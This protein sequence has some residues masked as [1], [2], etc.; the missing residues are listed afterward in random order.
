[1]KLTSRMC[2]THLLDADA[3]A[4]E[5]RAEIDRLAIE[6]DAPAWGHGH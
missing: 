2:S 3:L 6:A 5:D 4:G 1:M